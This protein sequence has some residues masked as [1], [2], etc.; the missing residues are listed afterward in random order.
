MDKLKQRFLFLVTIS[1]FFPILLDALFSQANSTDI[2]KVTIHFGALIAILIFDYIF[3]ELLDKW[4]HLI[5]KKLVNISVFVNLGAYAILFLIF[6]EL[7]AR[8]HLPNFISV[9]FIFLVNCLL[10]IPLIIF[11]LL[12]LNLVLKTDLKRE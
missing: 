9:I 4:S 8:E 7:Q 11:F 5:L 2:Y 6:N 10:Y 1:V 3:L 12:F